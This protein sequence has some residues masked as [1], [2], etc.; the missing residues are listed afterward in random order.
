M[1]VRSSGKEAM[2]PLFSTRLLA[3]GV[4]LLVIS[5]GAMVA[6]DLIA[7]VKTLRETYGKPVFVRHAEPQALPD[8]AFVD[9]EGR[10][11][12]LSDWHGQKVL[13][14]V[15]ATWCAPCKIEMPSLDRLQATLGGPN[16]SVIAL[17][18]DR[19]GPK[20]VRDFFS[21]E[22]LAHLKVYNDTLGVSAAL[23]KEPGLPLTILLDEKGQE[24]A[25][26]FGPAEWDSPRAIAA[27]EISKPH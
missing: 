5:M 25:R 3:F 8:I 21:R 6:P 4:G 24:I 13:L 11:V 7:N 16:F 2:A 19:G 15:W 26:H 14:N 27:L 17:S 1:T 10:T 9:G 18:T 23:L 22:G 20:I 12:H